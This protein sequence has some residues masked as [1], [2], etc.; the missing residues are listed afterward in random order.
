M[1]DVLLITA[2]FLSVLRPS[3]GVSSLA[4]VLQQN[5]YDCQVSYLNLAYAD[6]IGIDLNEMIC[7]DIPTSLLVGEAVFSDRMHRLG[8]DALRSYLQKLDK[9]I[10]H[11]NQQ[12]IMLAFQKV[13]LFLQKM[14]DEVTQKQPR[15]VGFS[16]TFQQNCASLQ[17]ARLIKNKNPDIITCFGGAN[18]EGP[19]GQAMLKHFA[20]VDQVFS[21][22]A[23]N[24]FLSFVDGVF[25]R[26]QRPATMISHQPAPLERSINASQPV[27]MERLP[28]PVYDDY[29]TALADSTFKDRIRPTILFETSRGCWWGAKHHCRFCGLN[30][31]HMNYRS[32][33]DQQVITELSRLNKQW[34]IND[35]QAADNIMD[36]KHVNTVFRQLPEVLPEASYFF[37]IKA[38]MKRS[39]LAIIARAGVKHVQPGIESLDDAVLKELEK[40]VSAAQNVCLLRDC[41]ELGIKV[42]WNV[43]CGIPN[44]TAEQYTAMANLLPALEH[45]DPPG[46]CSVVR[47]DRFSPYFEKADQLGFRHIKPCEAYQH[48]YDLDAAALDQ[49]AY[50]FTAVPMNVPAFDYVKPLRDAI[51]KWRAASHAGAS[52]PELKLLSTGDVHV[53]K[54]TRR[55]AKEVLYA[56]PPEEARLLV[57]LRKP[58]KIAAL[59]SRLDDQTVDWLAVHQRL[60]AR[61]LVVVLGGRSVSLVT[62]PDLQSQPDS[63]QPG[64]P[65][66]QLMPRKTIPLRTISS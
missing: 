24:S 15:I 43:L 1:T 5:Q 48:V 4:A 21:G 22:E 45:L 39:Q 46:G 50:F 62:M 28:I 54:D 58:S 49:L 44:D 51:S 10:S 36:L 3:L 18:C 7:E 17:L 19:M 60:L 16:S 23:E 42:I 40:G 63:Q 14:V 25:A 12:A 65:G 47:L 6:W 52:L 32:K 33:T 61:N 56:L 13:A 41:A 38:N 20:Q 55:I 8:P 11:N 66:G 64:Y 37:E 53:I 35:F 29:F 31:D 9:W 26:R 59:V 34:S 2:P 27:D 57:E 30:G